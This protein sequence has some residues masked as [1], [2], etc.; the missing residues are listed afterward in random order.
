MA[1]QSTDIKTYALNFRDLASELECTD[2][3]TTFGEKVRKVAT[4]PRAKAEPE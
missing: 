1:K 2:N 4:E 3:D